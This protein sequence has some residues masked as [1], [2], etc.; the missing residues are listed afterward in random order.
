MMQMKRSQLKKRG[1][2]LNRNRMNHEF[3]E[4]I[5]ICYELSSE[6]SSYISEIN[7]QTIIYEIKGTNVFQRHGL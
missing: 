7:G 1:A 4:F 2:L 5:I 6:T 3:I